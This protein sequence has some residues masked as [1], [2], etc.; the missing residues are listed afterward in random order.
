MSLRYYQRNHN[1]ILN[2][3][4][5][6]TVTQINNLGL[7]PYGVLRTPKLL[8]YMC[9]SHT[10]PGS[11]KQPPLLAQKQLKGS[12]NSEQNRQRKAPRKAGNS[13]YT[14][15]GQPSTLGTAREGTSGLT[16]IGGLP[17]TPQWTLEREAS[18]ASQGRTDP[19]IF[20]LTLLY[21]GNL[22]LFFLEP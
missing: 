19:C 2:R 18:W 1:F 21:K 16:V 3:S 14:P 17:L 7:V 4:V 8:T 6:K 22:S 10:R 20:S 11:W 13:P 9:H 15:W 12:L 5:S